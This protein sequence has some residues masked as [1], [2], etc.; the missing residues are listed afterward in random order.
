MDADAEH[1]RARGLRLGRDDG[2]LGADQPVEQG[3]LAGI[4][5]AEQ[6][7]EAGPARG[8]SSRS[9]RAAAAAAAAARLEPPDPLARSPLESAASTSNSG[10]V[11]GAAARADGIDRLA[12]RAGV[13]PLLQ[14]AA[15]VALHLRMAFDQRL[16]VAADELPRGVEPAVEEERR[17]DRLAGIR[18]RLLRHALFAGLRVPRTRAASRP[19]SL[20]TSISASS[21]TSTDMRSP[22]PPSSTSGKRSSSISATT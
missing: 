21:L 15:G 7:D 14:A 8:H 6:S 2:D 22:T 12:E 4:G 13:A 16:P 17:D 18:R 19:V 10:L 11:R 9:S 3:G 5:R 20:A 1:A